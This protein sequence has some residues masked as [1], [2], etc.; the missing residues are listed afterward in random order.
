VKHLD[1]EISHYRPELRPQVV[2]VL[3]HLLSGDDAADDT[4]FRWKYDHNPHTDD[5]LGIVA[6]HDGKVVGFRG[7]GGA[8]WRIGQSDQ[9]M[10]VLVPGDTVVHPDHRRKGLSVA[11]GK[12]AMTDYA[13]SYQVFLNL[14]CTRNSLPGYLRLGFAPLADKVY[15]SRYGLCSLT[16]Y[17]LAAKK[18]LDLSRA[19]LR[20]GQ[21]DDVQVADYPRPAEMASIASRRACGACGFNLSQGDDFFSW[22]FA[23]PKGKYVFY[24]RNTDREA[25]GYLV[26]G[27]TPSNRRGYVLDYADP[28]GES[29]GR[30]LEHVARSRRFSVLS[31]FAHSVDDALRPALS[32]L[33]FHAGGLLGAMERKVRGELPLLVRPVRPDPTDGD[34]LVAGRDIRDMSNWSIKGICSDDA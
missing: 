30:L 17:V 28:D 1:Y 20:Y 27:A 8:Q 33:G 7:Y 32:R 5:V 26:V 6:L 4:Y 9:V 23:G 29:A 15:L 18:E 31:I 2:E 14:S 24:Y 13:E 34:W 11:M 10:R 25:T 19:K 12:L 16:R 3:G 22:R 21:F